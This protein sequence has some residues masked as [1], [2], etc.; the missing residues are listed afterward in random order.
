MSTVLTGFRPLLKVTARQDA[1]RIVP[2]IALITALSVSS[3]VGYNWIFTTAAQ[4]ET[5][6]LTLGSNPV[7]SLLFGPAG[8]LTTADGFNTWRALALGGLF[9]SIMGAQIVVRGTRASEDSGRD[10]LI[11]S[12]VVGRHTR[13]M[14]A[15]GL[16]VLASI[17]LGFVCTALTF[18]VGGGFEAAL[19]LS[20]TFTACGLMGAGLAAVAA[21]LASTARTATTMVIAVLGA[22]YLTRGY[23]DA[24]DNAGWATWLTAFGWTQRV[25]P[26]TENNWW[27]L[28]LCLGLAVVLVI[29]ANA[30]L[31]RRDY[32]MGLIS[33]SPGPAR[34]GMVTSI[35]GFAL[36]LQAGTMI[37]WTVGFLVL[38]IVFGFLSGSISGLFAGNEEL[39]NLLTAGGGSPNMT[40]E[41]IRTL[42]KILALLA[43][44][45]GVQVMM[46]VYEEESSGRVEPVL[47]GSVT[48]P[49]YFAS[50]VVL[51]L[52]GP[53]V[54]MIVAGLGIGVVASARGFEGSGYVL[55]QAVATIPSVSL[56]TGI[57]IALVG[58]APRFRELAW[59]GVVG[60]FVLTVLGPMFRLWT[61][62]LAISPLWFT[63]DVILP[64]TDWAP[65]T[66]Q[67]V[68][69]AALVTMGFAGYRRRDIAGG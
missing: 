51:A 4:R 42:L 28:L 16:S 23:I 59:L 3:I 56:L 62:I 45:Y 61:W 8:D 58:F 63:P 24:S 9:A 21:Q 1:R 36:R 35:W 30:L 12:G 43:A 69:G 48:R 38:G 60:A 46:R 44:A 41:Y 18:A 34:G 15:V 14:V 33:P 22:S 66:V 55:F 50:H 27:P 68:I 64:G 5:L 31:A 10:E 7:F 47:A 54:A 39:A 29:L 40:F 57:G 25:R 52:F 67:T 20:L 13:L 17:A 2:W 49:R 32:G 6:A 19:S 65:P 26:G 53:A 11:A 37:A